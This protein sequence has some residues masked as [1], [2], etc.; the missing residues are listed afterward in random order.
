ML[1]VKSYESISCTVHVANTNIGHYLFVYIMD[2][3]YCIGRLAGTLLPDPQKAMDHFNLH[4][5]L[6]Y[7][8]YTHTVLPKLHPKHSY[9]NTNTNKHTHKNVETEDII[10]VFLV[11]TANAYR[12]RLKLL[13]RERQVCFI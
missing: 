12:N 13:Y 3:Q 2:F 9:T 5:S 1:P 7:L 6:I 11:I 10:N 8:I 4:F